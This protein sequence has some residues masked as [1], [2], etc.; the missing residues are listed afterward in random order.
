MKRLFTP[1]ALP[2]MLLSLLTS[3]LA[4]AH[5]LKVFAYA[6]GEQLHGNAYF[7]GGEPAV[8]ATI[9]LQAADGTPLQ[10]GQADAEGEFSFQLQQR[11]DLIL[12]ADS[13]DGHRAEWP[14]S[15]EEQSSALPAASGTPVSTTDSTTLNTA[16]QAVNAEQ[17]LALIERAVARQIGPLRRELQAN[18][19]RARLADIVGG[20]GLIFGCAGVALWW[21]SRRPSTKPSPQPNP[22]PQSHP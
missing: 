17:Q 6:E 7:A 1:V 3:P 14:V 11:R 10:Q 20:L 18:Q 19:Q 16:P 2:F 8:A 21:R 4:E 22:P 9:S 15:A 5:L 13:G 12:I